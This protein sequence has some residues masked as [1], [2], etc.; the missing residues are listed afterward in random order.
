MKYM[1]DK[2][3]TI[4]GFAETNT[5][6]H[7][8]NIK[9]QL[10]NETQSVFTTYSLAYSENRFNPPNISH[11]LPGG[12]LQLCTDHWTSRLLGTIKD[13]RGMSRWTGPKF[14]L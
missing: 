8:K 13:P 5:N 12:C 9:K 1:K 11:Y 2:G 7:S 3:I 4:S 10:S 6:W 14:H